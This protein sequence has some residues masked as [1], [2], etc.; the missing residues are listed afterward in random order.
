MHQL[1][2][3]RLFKKMLGVVLS[4]VF[5]YTVTVQICYDYF[6]TIIFG[7]LRFSHSKPTCPTCCNVDSDI[8]L[9]ECT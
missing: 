2:Y 5:S 7:V 9:W 1:A 4:P 8:G 3:A 6:L